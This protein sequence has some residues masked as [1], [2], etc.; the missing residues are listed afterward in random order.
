MC[1]SCWELAQKQFGTW[2]G[3]FALKDLAHRK[4]FSLDFSTYTEGKRALLQGSLEK[5][6]LSLGEWGS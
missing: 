3:R 1:D 6:L 5:C 2:V 4:L